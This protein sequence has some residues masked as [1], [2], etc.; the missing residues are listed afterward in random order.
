M[1]REGRVDPLFVQYANRIR[2]PLYGDK[3]AVPE[4]PLFHPRSRFFTLERSRRCTSNTL[5]MVAK[6]QELTKITTCHPAALPGNLEP[7]KRAIHEYVNNLHPAKVFPE[8]MS[9]IEITAI[10]RYEACRL[11]G[12]LYSSALVNDQRLS[13]AFEPSYLRESILENLVV[14]LKRSDSLHSECWGD[15]SGVLFWITFVGLV[16]AKDHRLGRWFRALYVRC[17]IVLGFEHRNAIIISL[18]NFMRATRGSNRLLVS[19]EVEEFERGNPIQGP[20]DAAAAVDE[21]SHT[22]ND[23]REEKSNLGSSRGSLDRHMAIGVMPPAVQPDFPAE[24]ESGSRY[25]AIDTEIEKHR[26]AIVERLMVVFEETFMSPVSPHSSRCPLNRGEASITEH[27]DH[28]NTAQH[29]ANPQEPATSHR[30]TI[31]GEGSGIVDSLAVVLC[32]PPEVVSDNVISCID[33]PGEGPSHEVPSDQM[34][35]AND[36]GYW[37]QQVRPGM[38]VPG[39][40]QNEASALLCDDVSGPSWADEQYPEIQLDSCFRTA[41]EEFSLPKENA[42]FDDMDLWTSFFEG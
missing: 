18:R 22:P 38:Q 24:F 21:A 2:V 8:L 15:M 36:S 5:E 42:N 14:A 16:A 35:Q 20:S 6:L 28:G 40:A 29:E 30:D 4:S 23:R 27:V 34:T 10:S 33:D 13:A 25:D 37:S 32:P 9:E 41:E 19:D 7:M 31:I 17:C 12:I 11:A 1:S 3:Q 26:H 39:D